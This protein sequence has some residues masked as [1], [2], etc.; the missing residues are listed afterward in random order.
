MTKP[1]TVREVIYEM[2]QCDM[3]QEVVITLR[4]GEDKPW[5]AG[6]SFKVMEVF[7]ISNQYPVLLTDGTL[8]D[9]K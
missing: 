9:L 4:A 3:D 7:A 6:V 2:L 1:M 8:E 5:T